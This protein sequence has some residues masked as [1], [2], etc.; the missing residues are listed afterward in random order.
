MYTYVLGIAMGLTPS[1]TISADDQLRR[2]EHSA[3]DQLRRDEHLLEQTFDETK[4]IVEQLRQQVRLNSNEAS[5]DSGERQRL[6]PLCLK[7]EERQQHLNF[8]RA[9]TRSRSVR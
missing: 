1:A 6:L 4:A 3:D 7:H 2:G 5:M 8:I 9:S